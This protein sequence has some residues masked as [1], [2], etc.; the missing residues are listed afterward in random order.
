MGSYGLGDRVRIIIPD[1]SDPDHQYHGKVG[2]V[3]EINMDCL[4]GLTGNPDDSYIYTI[5]LDDEELGIMD[6]RYRDLELKS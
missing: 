2:T 4:G 6:F 1:A 5:E 3:V